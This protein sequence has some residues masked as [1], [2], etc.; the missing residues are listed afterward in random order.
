MTEHAT[1]VLERSAEKMTT[2]LDAKKFGQIE[3]TEVRYEVARDSEDSL[4]ITLFL[5]LKDP[6]G[7]SW[8]FSDVLK[9]RHEIW[10][11]AD[12]IGLMVP[13][14]LRLRPET[15]SPQEDDDQT[16]FPA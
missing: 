11:E 13:I 12:E 9:L 2:V 15:D 7:D 1:D 16:L 4:A 3:V 6:Q 14:Y 10:R 8:P 5:T